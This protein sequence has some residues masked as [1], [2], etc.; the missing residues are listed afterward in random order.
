MFMHES[1]FSWF[2]VEER[3][4]R[5]ACRLAVL[6]LLL[7]LGACNPVETLRDWTGR[8]QN[9]PDPDT[10][11]NTRNLAAGEASDY[12][13]LA[14]VPPPPSRAMTAAD[15]EKLTQSLIADRANARHSDEQ[16]R[17]GP[18]A[19]PAAAPPPPSLASASEASP[20]EP[21]GGEP[22]SALSAPATSAAP[23][24]LPASPLPLSAP[25]PEPAR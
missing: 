2:G 23:S 22:A 19:A 16:L 13:N 10:T 4:S 3:A 25:S 21:S 12:P 5:S 20:S 15:R 11:P 8:S 7:G 1:L 6:A 17:A 9:D 24:S 14:T 18:S